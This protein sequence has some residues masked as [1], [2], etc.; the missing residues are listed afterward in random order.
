MKSEESYVSE[1]SLD[2]EM[3]GVKKTR[4]AKEKWMNSVHEVRKGVSDSGV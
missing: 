1:N 3:C 2:L 4:K